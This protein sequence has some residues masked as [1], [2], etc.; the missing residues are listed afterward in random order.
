MPEDV[1][2]TQLMFERSYKKKVK[3]CKYF[4]LYLNINSLFIKFLA[5]LDTSLIYVQFLNLKL[6]FLKIEFFFLDYPLKG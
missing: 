4:Y 5:K 2:L 3:N 6:S 1:L